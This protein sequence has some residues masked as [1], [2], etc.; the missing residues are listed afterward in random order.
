M[1]AHLL[2]GGRRVLLLDALAAAW[3]LAW[4]ILALLI[5][6]EVR[7]LR[8]LSVTAERTGRAVQEVG[9]ALDAIDVPFVGDRIDEAAK[10]VTVA[11]QSTVESA[12]RT[13]ESVNDLQVLLGLAVGL[14][15]VS[16]VLLIYLPLRVVDVRERRALAALR[17]RARSD[18]EL[19]A[20]LARR[21]IEEMSYRRLV[22][23]EGRPWAERPAPEGR[24]AAE[25]TAARVGTDRR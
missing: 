23:V 16:P 10:S 17:V 25:V 6:D 7:G 5:A 11:G 24:G 14:I 1:W 4:L 2:P 20:L 9:S 19:A 8:A 3:I 22:G 21:T 12:R 18:P 15:P 13:R